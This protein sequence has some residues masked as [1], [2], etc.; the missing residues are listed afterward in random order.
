M[1]R[2]LRVEHAKIWGRFSVNDIISN[3]WKAFILNI[4]DHCLDEV[5]IRDRNNSRVS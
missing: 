3:G 4:T 2:P 5:K 1:G